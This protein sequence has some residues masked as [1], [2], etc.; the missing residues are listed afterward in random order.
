MPAIKKSVRI[1]EQAQEVID[2]FGF[3]IIDG[4]I[5]WSGCINEIT[6]QFEVMARENEP[7]LPDAMWIALKDYYLEYKDKNG[8]GHSIDTLLLGA[9]KLNKDFPGLFLTVEEWSETQ[10]LAA[11][12]NI[13]QIISETIYK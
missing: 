9:A 3:G 8:S 2:V 4:D 10:K 13:K 7:S 12:H 11:I 6:R 5:N 1:I